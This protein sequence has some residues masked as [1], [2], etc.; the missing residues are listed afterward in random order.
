MTKVPCL[1]SLFGGFAVAW[2]EAAIKGAV[3]IA[4]SF[5][6]SDLVVGLS[7]VAVGTSLPELAA[8]LASLK[9]SMIWPWA[10]S[11]VPMCCACWV[12]GLGVLGTCC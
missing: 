5:G 12:C 1:V 7:I 6:V 2:A 8:S 10:M 11:L 9:V 4:Q 3:G